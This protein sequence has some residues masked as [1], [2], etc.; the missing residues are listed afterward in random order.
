VNGLDEP[1]RLIVAITGASGA[2]YGTRILELCAELQDVE[3]HLVISRGA[4]STIQSETGMTVAKVSGM[5]DVVY[6]D[7]DL[8]AAISSGSFPTAGMIVAPCSIKTLSGIANAY[9]DN[10]VVR[11]ADVT[12]K[13]G[14]PLLLLVRETPLH[15]GHLRLMSMATES[16]AII[17]PPVPAFYTSP[18]TVEDI[19][20]HTARRAL[21]R[22]GITTAGTIRWNGLRAGA[23]I[24]NA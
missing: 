7:A 9:D 10:L 2:A 24:R 12:L 3:T 18:A 8:G 17:Y 22:I 15:A 6:S 1:R 16:G 5:A 23:D 14:R 20:D 11:S 21:E 4:R 13:E 19:V